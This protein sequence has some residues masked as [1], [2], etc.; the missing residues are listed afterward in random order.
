VIATIVFTV[1]LSGFAALIIGGALQH[2]EANRANPFT[3]RVR[4]SKTKNK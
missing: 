3:S 4:G 2:H 1:L